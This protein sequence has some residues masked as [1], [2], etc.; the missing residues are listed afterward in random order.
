MDTF[1]LVFFSLFFLLA[2][3]YI[4]TPLFLALIGFPILVVVG[5]IIVLVGSYLKEVISKDQR[6]PVAGPMLNQLIHF[7]RMFDYQT[8]LAQKQTTFRFITPSHSEVYT[9]DPVNVEYLLKTNFS[10]YGKVIL[11]VFALAHQLINLSWRLFTWSS[12]IS[13]SVHAHVGPVGNVAKRIGPNCDILAHMKGY[14]WY[15]RS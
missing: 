11:F 7:N 4:S 13:E 10:N 9:A 8:S 5:S 12:L 14:D 2:G 6:P 1:F 3:L 15:D